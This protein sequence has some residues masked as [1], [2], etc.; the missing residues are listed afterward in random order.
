M[1]EK[2]KGSATLISLGSMMAIVMAVGVFWNAVADDRSR[3]SALEEA[4]GTI[5]VD[6][7]IIKDDIKT[8][9]TR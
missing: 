5:K 9:L 1:K 3:I 7:T 4:V 8:L 6:T 2:I